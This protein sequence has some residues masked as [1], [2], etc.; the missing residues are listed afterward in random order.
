M[1]ALAL[2]SPGYRRSTAAEVRVVSDA[3]LVALM[4]AGQ[5]IAWGEFAA[6]FHPVLEAFARRAGIPASDWSVCVTEVLDDEA[7]RLATPEASLPTNLG[8]YLVRA[9]HHRYLRLKRSRA[10]RDRH[11]LL[12]SDDFVG[13]RVVGALCSEHMVRASQDGTELALDDGSEGA[14]GRL[15]CAIGTDLTAEERLILGWVSQRVSH[16][17][18]AEWLGVGYDAATK[19]I[20][21]LC[22]RVRGALPRHLEPLAA[23]DRREIERFFRRAG[24]PLT[25]A[26]SGRGGAARLA[27]QEVESI[28][29]R[30]RGPEVERLA[31]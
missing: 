31:R 28:D 26:D 25:A 22:R 2:D 10:C 11:Y 13:E 12:A 5:A 21:R 15:A 29:V 8:G 19:R 3:Q 4:R 20:W 30:S 23:D 16:R 7:L 6:R 14:V 17:Q 1:H 27:A 18:I 9:V 24:T